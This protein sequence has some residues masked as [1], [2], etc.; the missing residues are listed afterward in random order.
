A[1]RKR[2]PPAAAGAAQR[3]Q[4]G[5]RAHHPDQAAGPPVVTRAAPRLGNDRL[6][7]WGP[8][9]AVVSFPG[10][11]CV[12]NSHAACVRR[13]VTPRPAGLTR[14]SYTGRHDEQTASDLRRRWL[15]TLSNAPVNT[16]D[17]QLDRSFDNVSP[18]LDLGTTLLAGSGPGRTRNDNFVT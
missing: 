17:L 10:A 11:R 8:G 15:S 9:C 18:H 12:D 6:R 7:T 14:P 2:D 16:T 1:R 3:L 5:H 13:S 4:P